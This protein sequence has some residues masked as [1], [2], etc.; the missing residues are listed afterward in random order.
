MG[1]RLRVA[2]AA[3]AAALAWRSGESTVRAAPRPRFEPTDLEWEDTGVAELDLQFGPVQ[4]DGPWRIVV[5]DF[6]L[7]L[8][9]LPWLELD[10][11]GAYAVEGPEMGPFSLD[12][13][14][15]DALWPSVKLGIFGIHDTGG[16]Y[17]AAF[18]LQVGPK[19]PVASGSHGVGLEMLLIFGGMVGHLTTAMNAGA[20]LDPAPDPA[21]DR[22]A[23]INLGVDLL[24]KLGNEDRYA[25]TGE[26]SGTR[27]LSPD[28]DQ[29]QATL[30]F[31][32]SARPTLDLSIT[33]L[34]GTPT[35][36]D[37][38]GILFGISPKV[39]LFR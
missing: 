39:R 16:A 2:V 26:V 18:G 10:L 33:G 11:D 12:H 23:G 38:Y 22:R 25:L 36:G 24:Y 8:G 32:W 27:F 28:P 3:L 7:D 15:P 9:L 1:R 31:V 13:S 5:P 30:G 34:I 20:F 35:G 29:L 14:A 4:G 6:E 17:G 37:R 19:L 21:S